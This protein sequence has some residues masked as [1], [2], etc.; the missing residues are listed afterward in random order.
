MAGKDFDSP[1]V[2]IIVPAFDMDRFVERTLLSAIGQTYRNLEIIVIDDGSTDKTLQIARRVAAEH[3]KVRVVSVA[4]AGVAAARNMGIE[5]AD[6][7]Y[8]AFLDA[9]DLWH[10]S[11]IERQVAAL[12]AHGHSE[13]WAA[14]YSLYRMIDEDDMVVDNGVPAE[15]RGDFFDAQL[16]W[17]PVGNGSN[18]LVRRDVALAVGGFNPDYANAGVGGCEDLEFQLKVLQHHKVELVREYAIGYRLHERQMSSNL[19]AMRLSRIA[20]I[21]F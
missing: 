21:E 17:N 11:K 4:N 2:T 1:R 12:A 20:V 16:L 19:S 9:D 14:C 13:E 10:P 6:S 3:P 7:L 5:L 18:L 8:V 15:A